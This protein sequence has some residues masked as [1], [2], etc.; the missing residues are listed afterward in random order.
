M[1]QE[2]GATGERAFRSHGP[3]V[4]IRCTFERLAHA[5]AAKALPRWHAKDAE[6]AVSR[7]LFVP[8][9]AKGAPRQI[10]GV[11]IVRGSEWLA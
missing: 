2:S 3:V 4:S 6:L 7:A 11:R 1:G 9:V 8:L 10:G 5:A